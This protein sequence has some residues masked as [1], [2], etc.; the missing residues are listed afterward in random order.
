MKRSFKIR[1]LSQNSEL[2]VSGKIEITE[3]GIFI[4]F[5]G[6]GSREEGPGG[7]IVGIEV[8]RGTLR[9]VA[10]SDPENADATHVINLNG[11]KIGKSKRKE[12]R[13]C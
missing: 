3:A 2:E 1:D 6:F 13:K 11:A 7:D 12:R 10:W 5:D 9:L 8:W 4:G